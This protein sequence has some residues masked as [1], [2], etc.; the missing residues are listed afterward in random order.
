MPGRITPLVNNEIY[1]IFNRGIASQPTFIDKRDY[2]RAMDTIFYYQNV[3]LPV[4]YSRFLSLSLEERNDIL[5][6]LRNQKEFL[7]EI[8]ALC[9]MPNHFHLLIRQ[10]IDNGI[11]HFVSNFTN[12]YTR[13]FNTKR[14]RTGP[15]FEGKFKSV[16]IETEEQL[17]HVSRYIHLNP[18]TAFILKKMEDLENY[19]YSSFNEYVKNSTPAF[20]AKDIVLSNFKSREA[21]KQFVFDQASYQRTLNRI[22]HLLLE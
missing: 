6:K 17:L 9:L 16:R 18:Y 3:N 14:E 7:V 5:E 15:I 8:I 22:K 21:Y 19:S 2:Q 4:K 20:Y 12:S 11:S 13:F 10:L 1:H